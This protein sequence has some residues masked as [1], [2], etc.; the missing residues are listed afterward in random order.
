MNQLFS[1]KII[2]FRQRLGGARS[3]VLLRIGKQT[4]KMN[5]DFANQFKPNCR[6]RA[7]EQ[8]L[9]GGKLA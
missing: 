4:L 1:R 9:K 3:P 2:R 5:S 6:Q 7:N 8:I